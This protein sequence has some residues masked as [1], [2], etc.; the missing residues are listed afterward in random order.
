MTHVPENDKVGEARTSCANL[1]FTFDSTILSG[2][3]SFAYPTLES[4]VYNPSSTVNYHSDSL[5]VADTTLW[6]GTDV[7]TSKLWKGGLANDGFW[8]NTTGHY[9]LVR[10]YYKC[11]GQNANKEKVVTLVVDKDAVNINGVLY[12]LETYSWEM[13]V[14]QVGYFG[15]DCNSHN[16]RGVSLYSKSCKR[17]PASF[18]VTPQQISTATVTPVDS[19]LVTKTF[20]HSVRGVRACENSNHERYVIFLNLM[21]FDDQHV[22]HEMPKHDLNSPDKVFLDTPQSDFDLKNASEFSTTTEFVDYYNSRD[23]TMSEGVYKM[24]RITLMI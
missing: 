18:S 16:P 14:C 11:Q 6:T 22:L 2:E 5:M 10:T 12:D 13:K 21:L 24:K 15:Q 3:N 20:L 19:N 1:N 4:G 9:D 8:F 17:F 7:P 23:V